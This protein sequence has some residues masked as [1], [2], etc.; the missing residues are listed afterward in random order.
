ME[1]SMRKVV[2]SD[3]DFITLDINKMTLHITH[4][5][6]A[7][8]SFFYTSQSFAIDE[9]SASEPHSTPNFGPLLSYAQAPLQ[10]NSLTPQLRSGYSMENGSTEVYSALTAASIWIKTRDYRADYYQNQ[11][12]IGTK[13]Q[14]TPQ[15][16]L[17]LHYRWNYAS[18]NYL[19]GPIEGFHDFF[20]IQHNGRD[21]VD[22]HQFNIAVPKYNIR[23]DDF[24][25]DTISS[26]FTFYA[27]YQL[28]A[29]EHHGLSAGT[30][31]FYNRVPN[32][33]FEGH[34]LEQSLQLNYE[35]RVADHS[36]FTNVG[37]V[38]QYDAQTIGDLPHNTLRYSWA[39]GYQFQFIEN[40]ELHLEYRLYEGAE[41]G[42]SDLSFA[43]HEILAGYRYRM[44]NSAIELLFVEN[45]VNM[46]NS[47]DIA[48]QIG[49]RYQFR[50]N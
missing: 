18:N 43:V 27:Q 44:E 17:D 36:L 14:A 15:L 8:L 11:L 2:E 1:A 40:H 21:Q 29:V 12:F 4:F 6:F 37:V 20:S 23:V 49:Y 34:Q 50:S 47:T 30:S 25:G 3:Y 45:V 38:Y 48:F 5:I 46:D 32:G 13:W 7:A 19:D 41:N 22:D 33:A 9:L 31:I 42:I 28:I 16:Q 24:E 26:A 10:T 35:F 39:G